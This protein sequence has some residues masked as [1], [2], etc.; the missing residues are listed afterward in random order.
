MDVTP[1]E[2][3]T[4]IQPDAQTELSAGNV[5]VMFPVTSRARTYQAM[6]SES[7]DCG[8]DALTCVMTSIY[9][10]EGESESD[11]RLISPAKIAI[12]LS[13]ERV[14]A[15]GGAAVSLQ[16]YALRGVRLQVADGANSDWNSIPFEFDLNSDGSATVSAM[17]RRFSALTALNVDADVVDQATLLLSMAL[18]TPTAAP[19]PTV[20]LEPTVTPEPEPAPDGTTPPDSDARAGADSDARAG[21]DANSDA[22][23][24]Y[25]GR[26]RRLAS[27]R[28]SAGDGRRRGF[29]GSGRNQVH[30]R[31]QR[32]LVPSPHI[33]GMNI[34]N[35]L[36]SGIFPSEVVPEH[37]CKQV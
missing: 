23:T 8:G 33:F 25:T 15:L 11:A 27:I 30:N 26:G 31:T 22:G 9:N 29:A 10:A 14:E 13:A 16:T 34:R 1:V 17:T 35:E 37:D 5:S 21:A 20:T 18:G 3:A 6:V 4:T 32:T 12:T 7:D 36:N 19:I 24:D 28:P 2:G